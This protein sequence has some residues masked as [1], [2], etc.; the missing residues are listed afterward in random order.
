VPV[1]VSGV[2][3]VEEF[4]VV[5]ERHALASGHIP[6]GQGKVVLVAGLPIGVTGG[7]NLLR[8][9]DIPSDAKTD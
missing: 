9:M 8:V 1:I 7:T 3:N 4:F 2:R 5:G 6:D